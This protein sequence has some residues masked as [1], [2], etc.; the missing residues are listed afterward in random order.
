MYFVFKNNQNEEITLTESEIKML[1]D[2]FL[3]VEIDSISGK[4][5]KDTCFVQVLKNEETE[6]RNLYFFQSQ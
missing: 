5:F 3:F 2:E 6:K 1:W 4:F